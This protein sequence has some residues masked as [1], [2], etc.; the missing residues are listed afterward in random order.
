MVLPLLNLPEGLLDPFLGAAFR[1]VDNDD[2]RALR[3]VSKCFCR[4]TD[5]TITGVFAG[6]EYDERYKYEELPVLVK[7]A[8]KLEV[9]CFGY[10]VYDKPDLAMPA[11]PYARASNYLGSVME[12]V[13]EADDAVKS[14]A[15]AGWDLRRL[16]L[17]GMGIGPQGAKALTSAPLP[18]LQH[19]TLCENVLVGVDS[20]QALASAHWPEL[21]YL[22]VSNCNLDNGGAAELRNARFPELRFL[23]ISSNSFGAS[24]AAGVA[25]AHL[26]K[27]E[28]LSAGYNLSLKDDEGGVESLVAG[29]W[30]NLRRLWLEGIEMEHGGAAAL[31]AGNFPNLEELDLRHNW[32]GDEGAAALASGRW[33]GLKELDV[34]K[35]NIGDD[36]LAALRRRWP[37]PAMISY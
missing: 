4:L 26:P 30:P 9:F 1:Q 6:S 5:R 10:K 18:R 2:K 22:D 33:P 7:A 14:F 25:A 8:W 27:L 37:R 32:L 15:G 11:W 21:R 20:G 31:A 12:V 3:L 29:R 28:M 19:L 24:G 35:N 36:G 16:E 13:K 34:R 23:D 17:S